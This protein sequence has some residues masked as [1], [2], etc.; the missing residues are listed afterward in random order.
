MPTQAWD[1]TPGEQRRVG[2]AL[3]VAFSVGENDRGSNAPHIP[4][5]GATKRRA[6]EFAALS[7]NCNASNA[8]E[9]CRAHR[10]MRQVSAKCRPK[11]QLWPAGFWLLT[12]SCT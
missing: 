3:P 1:M 10:S 12:M 6:T 7:V 11:V 5:A 8:D 4:A 2:R 9:N